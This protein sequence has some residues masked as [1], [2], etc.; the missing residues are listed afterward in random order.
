MSNQLKRFLNLSQTELFLILGIPLVLF[1]LGTFMK[2]IAYAPRIQ[3][4]ELSDRESLQW[5]IEF[6]VMA[7]GIYWRAT[8]SMSLFGQPQKVFAFVL[9][10]TLLAGC[11]FARNRLNRRPWWD[12][13]TSN[14]IGA[15]SLGLAL[16]SLLDLEVA[17]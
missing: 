9:L 11:S 1:I 8:Y 16:F 6:C 10:I 7:L 12:L 13:V 3:R 14:L 4:G 15:T 2:G 17:R 5:G